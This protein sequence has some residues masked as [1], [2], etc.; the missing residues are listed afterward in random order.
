MTGNQVRD[1]LGATPFR[2]FSLLLTDG[3][4]VVIDHPDL[5]KGS[6][7]ERLLTIYSR[8]DQVEV[9]DLTHVVSVRFRLPHL[10]DD[11]APESP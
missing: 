5:V 3:R 4:S 11:A 9:V 2:T 10:F 1:L 6:G 7:D 8:P